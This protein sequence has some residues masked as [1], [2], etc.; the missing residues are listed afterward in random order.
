MEGFLFAGF[1]CKLERTFIDLHGIEGEITGFI[2]VLVL[3]PMGFLAAFPL[4]LRIGWWTVLLALQ[5]NVQAH[6]FGYG[7]EEF[8][9][10]VMLHI[11]TAF[12]ILLLALYLTFQ[13][14]GALQADQRS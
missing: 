2:L 14:R 6:L 11:P 5:W 7:I 1:Y 8:L 13:A 12:G 10:M 9:W 3:V 4:R